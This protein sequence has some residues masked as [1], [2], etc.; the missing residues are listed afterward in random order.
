MLRSVW[1]HSSTPGL[2][3]L[4]MKALVRTLWAAGCRECGKAASTSG[5]GG[6]MIKGTG[7]ADEDEFLDHDI[8]TYR[9]LTH[10][11]RDLEYALQVCCG[12]LRW[13]MVEG[14]GTSEV[15]L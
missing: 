15:A 1:V 11:F 5:A 3:A 12:G 14:G 9:R 8:T 13:L 7:Q 10:I 4:V 6:R 2:I